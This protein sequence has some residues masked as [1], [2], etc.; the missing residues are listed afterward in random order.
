LHDAALAFVCTQA[1][2]Q[3]PQFAVVVVEV[4]QPL[5]LA[6]AFTQSAKL[7]LQVYEQ[8]LALHDAAD[9]LVKVHTLPQPPQFAVD[10][11]V[12]VS[13]PS[14]ASGTAG[15]TQLPR[16]ALQVEVHSPPAQASVATPVFEQPRPHAPQFAVEVVMLV[17]QPSV[18][19]PTFTQSPK[20]TL[21]LYEQ[22]VPLQLAV[23]AL[24]AVQATPQPP[25]L[26][27]VVVEVS[28]PLVLAPAFTQSA[29]FALQVYE[30]VLALQVAADALVRLHTLPQPPQFDV[31]VVVLVSH[32]SVLAPAFTQSPKLALQV[33]E[34]AVPLQLAALAFVSVHTLPQP[35]Q[36]DVVVVSVSHPLR[37]GAALLQSARPALQPV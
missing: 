3:P 13:Q 16:P 19:A 22:L 26:A 1:L 31:D 8:V 35:P 23:L 34:H 36:F 2:P 20:P 18:L 27:M 11:V 24:V 29:K 9:A 37:S 5:V 25:Q 10:E 14:S 12:S 32:P 17:S 4:S 21:Q 28:Q 33:Y 30:Q 6:P 15:R 7:A